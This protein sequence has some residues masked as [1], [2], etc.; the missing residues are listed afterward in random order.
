MVI[1]P[2]ITLMVDQKR[3]FIHKGITVEFVGD[4]QDSE[5]ATK[6]VIRGDVQLVYISPESIL[7]N[8]KFRN[9]LQNSKYQ[10]KLVALVVDEVHCVQMW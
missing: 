2:L 1:S 7:N 3:N 6:S 4:A 5:E 9:M 10:E 8:R